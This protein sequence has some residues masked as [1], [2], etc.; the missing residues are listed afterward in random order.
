MARELNRCPVLTGAG[1]PS[2]IG[3]DLPPTITTGRSSTGHRA[4]RAESSRGIAHHLK[5]LLL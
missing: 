1:T 2:G 3:A 5:E 4:P